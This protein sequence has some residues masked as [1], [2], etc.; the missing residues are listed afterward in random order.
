MNK[1]EEWLVKMLEFQVSLF[2]IFTNDNI[3]SY[4]YMLIIQNASHISY[5]RMPALRYNAHRKFKFGE[6]M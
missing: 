2:F 3:M 5:M 6:R 1:S 4:A